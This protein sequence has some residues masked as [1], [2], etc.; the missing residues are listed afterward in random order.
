M[1]I[2]KDN[3]VPVRI[4]QHRIIQKKICKYP[5]SRR[6]AKNLICTI[7]FRSVTYYVL[8]SQK[9]GRCGR[10][11]G[12][13]GPRGTAQQ[14]ARTTGERVGKERTQISLKRLG[15]EIDFKRA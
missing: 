5:E 6:S 2:E 1:L 14:C 7:I 13:L 9:F 8:F 12:G 4:C 11:Y 10:I 15:H 3:T